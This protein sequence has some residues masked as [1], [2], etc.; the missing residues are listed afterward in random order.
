M[1]ERIIAAGAPGSGKT[2][3]WLT[4]ARML[5]DVTF[6][7]L[8]PDDGVLRLLYS[9]FSDVKNLNYYFTPTWFGDL[10]KYELGQTGGVIKAFKDL[11]PKVKK[12]DWVIVEMLGNMWSM[13]QSGFANEVFQEGIGEYFLR[14]RKEMRENATRLDA[15]KGWT[16]WIVI[17]KMHNEDFMNKVCYELPS[18]VYMT[19]S[20][21]IIAPSAVSK[22]EAEQR[23]FYGD[24]LIRID[25]QKAN[26]FRA[27]SIFLNVKRKKEW[28]YSTFIK[29]RGRE[30]V[31][32]EKVSDFGFQYLV[33]VAKWEI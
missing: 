32:N 5:P 20:S 10:E 31:E 30:F 17:N 15:I 27:Q 16:D 7:V 23:A 24:S 28:F 22:E 6:H 12:G 18:N 21:S 26:I 1:R 3:N 14:V 9:E 4:I 25:G 19:T 11:K 33:G 13:A 29:D 2:Y 8:D